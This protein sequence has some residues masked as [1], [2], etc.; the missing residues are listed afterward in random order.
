MTGSRALFSASIV[1]TANNK[2]TETSIIF[3]K[4]ISLAILDSVLLTSQ[5]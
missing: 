1:K 3:V 2:L 4:L 5:K